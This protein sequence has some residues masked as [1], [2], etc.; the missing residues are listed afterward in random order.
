MTKR[1][2]FLGTGLMGAPM[3]SR[4]LGAGFAVTV[5]NR[6]AEKAAP[7]VDA[8][9]R[10]CAS[11]AEAV[12]DAEVVCLCLTDATAIED[13]LFAEG[14][15]AE[16]LPADAILVDFSTIGPRLTRVL[17]ERLAERRPRIEWI[18]APVSGGV[19]G[20]ES[21]ELVV[22]CGGEAAAVETVRPLLAP[23]AKRVCH[24][25]PL[26]SGQAAKLCNQLIVA[27][28]I[29]AI[30]EAFALAR[31]QGIAPALLPDALQGG[32][33]DSLPLQIIGRRM[34]EG[35]AEPVIVAVSTY[36]KDLTLVLDADRG[37]ARS[38]MADAA[39][40]TFRKATA[41]GL[42]DVDVSALLAFIE[43]S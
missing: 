13:V 40:M 17:A 42:A 27:T 28:N 18:D 6:S 22:M 23:L 5:W 35:I 37:L 29:L 20:A 25:G 34:A 11:A 2:A 1:V 15:I 19:R 31:R 4:L 21:G 3:A 33:A 41:A 16:A 36:V 26:G 30:G 12:A 24:L 10:G 43:A 9:A 8:G 7:L 32:W 14:G 39:M 38:G